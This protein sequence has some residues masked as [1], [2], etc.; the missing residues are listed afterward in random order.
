MEK[1]K[2][3]TWEEML[4]PVVVLSVICLVVS[5]LLGYFNGVTKPIID[6]N[7]ARAADEAR[8]E[9]LPDAT[10][11][12]TLMETDMDGI[13]E[14][15]K[16]NNGVGYVISSASKGYSGDIIMMTAFDN[17]GKIV[18][19]KV[20]QQTETA[21]QGSRITERAFLDQFVGREDELTNSNVDMIAQS[22]ISSKAAMSA[23]NT[24]RKAF[25]EYVKGEV[26]VE[27]TLEEKLGRLFGEDK[28]AAV[29]STDYSNPDAVAFYT[30]E[31]GGLIVCSEGRGNG[32]LGD[33]HVTGEYLKAYVAFN[34]DGTIAGVYFDASSETQNLGDQIC[35]ETFT[36]QFIGKEDA[37]GVDV[38]ANVTYSSKGAFEAVNK[39]C[40]VYAALPNK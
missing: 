26:V 2:T 1:Q 10:E 34:D 30:V 29:L 35:E 37:S 28:P 5:A 33:E 16:A 31:G 15:Y 7:A 14:M 19:L 4:K 8:M 38:I 21:G 17:D 22:T 6:R 18:Q 27:L 13:K 25:N 11:G 36:S 3:S 40:A 9:L 39:A 23:L 32:I 20:Q 12:F 24:A